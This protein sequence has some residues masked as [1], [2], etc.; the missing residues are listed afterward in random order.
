MISKDQNIV[1]IGPSGSGKG[2]QAEF[3]VKTYGQKHIIAGDVLRE[4]TLG[5]STFGKLI[6]EKITQGIFIDDKL[7]NEAIMQKVKDVPKD[8][9]IIIDGFPRTIGQAKYLEELIGEEGKKVPIAIYL[10][11]SEKSVTYRMVNRRVCESCGELYHPPKSM[12]LKSCEKCAGKLI[13]RVDDNEEA[14]QK[15]L[16]QFREEVMPVIN[17]YRAK[18]RIIDIDGEPEIVKVSQE[19]KEKLDKYHDNDES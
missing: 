16:R 11:V 14:I 19:I 6:K 10:N 8:Q 18:N 12:S 15:R 9:G 4:I 13:K 1:I 7:V 5:N 2:T 17:F 3:I